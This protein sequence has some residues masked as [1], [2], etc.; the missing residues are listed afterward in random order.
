MRTA[1]LHISCVLRCSGINSRFYGSIHTAFSHIFC[2]EAIR[3]IFQLPWVFFNGSF[4]HTPWILGWSGRTSLR[5]CIALILILRFLERSGTSNSSHVSFLMTSLHISW[6]LRS[7]GTSYSSHRSMRTASL[8]IPGVFKL[9]GTN[10]K[11]RGLMY[12]N[13]LHGTYFNKTL[14]F[15]SI[16]LSLWWVKFYGQKIFVSGHQ[17]QKDSCLCPQFFCFF[18]LV[19]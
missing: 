8:H 16:S 13:H 5:R 17:I 14:I 10:I 1:L 7:S 6:V 9:S 18:F 12:V 15:I 19:F 11:K 4:T 2:L 3:D